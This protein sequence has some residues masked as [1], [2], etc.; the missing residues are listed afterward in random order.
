ML[1][2]LSGGSDYEKSQSAHSAFVGFF[3]ATFLRLLEHFVFPYRNRKTS[4]TA[5]TLCASFAK[6]NR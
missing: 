2:R 6:K 1:R 4:F 3:S 5:G